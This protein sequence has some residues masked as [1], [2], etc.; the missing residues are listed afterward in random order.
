MEKHLEVICVGMAVADVLVEGV[1]EIP[2]EGETNLVK[3]I[4]ISTGGDAVNEAIT[5]ARLGHSVGLMALVGND[6][7]GDFVVSECQKN[8]VDV[9]TIARTAEHPTATSVVLINES[10]E[11]SFLSQPDTALDAFSLEH[12]D[13]ERIKPGLKVLSVGSLFCGKRMHSEALRKILE[14]AKGV[15]AITVADFVPSQ[16]AEGLKTIRGVLELVDFAVPSREEAV[17]YAE[18]KDL[19]EI[20]K[21]FF[22]YGVKNVLVKLGREGISVHTA[23]DRFR[24]GL[25]PAVAVDTTGAGDSFVAGFISGLLRK[26]PLLD[27]VKCGAATASIAIQSI[28][29]TT[30]VQSLEQV[31]DV[32]RRHE[33]SVF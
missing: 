25:Y 20:A 4:N 21:V 11:R 17:L 30:G 2:R 13:L 26:E 27:C 32:I 19:D 18:A 24:L 31:K 12:I 6:L 5:L 33:I 1:S 29:A 28:G 10:G 16:R 15:G 22:R 8:G 23:R 14:R 3:G 9:S 7:Q